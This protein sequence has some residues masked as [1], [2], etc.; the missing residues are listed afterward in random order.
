MPPL[1]HWYRFT[2]TTPSTS[3]IHTVPVWAGT[4]TPRER[5]TR[6]TDRLRARYAHER[7]AII[8]YT[9]ETFPY[10]K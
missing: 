1:L 2:V 5:I 9:R 7:R 8:T 6:A 3:T 4:R 10:K